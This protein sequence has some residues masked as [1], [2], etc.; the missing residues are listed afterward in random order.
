MDLNNLSQLHIGTDDIT[1]ETVESDIGASWDAQA[2]DD[3][4]SSVSD[5]EEDLSN[6]LD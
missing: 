6:A 5:E 4:F 1:I 3:I 2:W